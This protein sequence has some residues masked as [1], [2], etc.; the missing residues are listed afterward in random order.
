MLPIYLIYAY[1]P[2]FFYINIF[3]Y[4]I[5][6]VPLK[7]GNKLFLLSG[8]LAESKQVT[9]IQ[10]VWEA[11]GR[12][13]ASMRKVAE[14]ANKQAFRKKGKQSIGKQ[15]IGRQSIGRQATGRYATSRQVLGREANIWQKYS[16]TLRTWVSTVAPIFFTIS[17]IFFVAVNFGPFSFFKSLSGVWCWTLIG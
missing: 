4:C 13:T 17:I 1:I 10:V 12:R 8:W 14:R 16:Y 7:T 5:N 6:N 11:T 9:D 2:W 3:T 15:A